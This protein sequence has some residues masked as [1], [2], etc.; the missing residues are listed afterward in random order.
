MDTNIG[1]GRV[2]LTLSSLANNATYDYHLTHFVSHRIRQKG[3][4]AN[5]WT[6]SFAAK[7]RC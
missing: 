3:I 6:Y 5:T 4:G 7:E 2:A 1:T